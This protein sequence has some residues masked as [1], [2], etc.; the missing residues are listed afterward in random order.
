MQI[1]L[2]Q[3]YCSKHNYQIMSTKIGML[4]LFV[5]LKEKH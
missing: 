3:R 2:G 5:T 4:L 1:R